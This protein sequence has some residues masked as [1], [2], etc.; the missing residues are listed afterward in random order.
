MR[1]KMTARALGGRVIS[2]ESTRQS[3]GGRVGQPPARACA[4]RQRGPV[5]LNDP[6]A[7]GGDPHAVSIRRQ[8]EP[9]P[10]DGKGEYISIDRK[11]PRRDLS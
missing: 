6:R 4:P 11:Q 9:A 3:V 1:H 8:L 2:G 5:L 7:F 10:R